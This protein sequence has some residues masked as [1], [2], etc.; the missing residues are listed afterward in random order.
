MPHLKTIKFHASN[1]V[2]TEALSVKIN[3]S[4]AG[5]FYCYLP[6]YLLPAVRD[7]FNIS[8]YIE[9]PEKIKVTET[10]LKELEF[11]IQRSLNIY[12]KPEILKYPVIL[13]N[14]ESHTSFAEDKDGNIFP[15]AGFNGASWKDDRDRYGNHHASNP[16]HGGYSLIIGAQAKM[17]IIH[18]YGT[19]EKIKY[20]PYYNGG[21]H[22]GNK[23]PAELLNSWCSYSLGDNPKEMAYTDDAALFFY[24]LMMGMAKLSKIIQDK[25]FNQIDLLTMIKDKSILML[26]IK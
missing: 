25:T 22:L 21:H 11:N 19:I 7:S 20:K 6:G 2:E 24:D 4:A 9:N 15:N 1:E 10:T 17:K 23:N 13:Y 18:K 26:P 14:I 5:D 12:T 16:S 8:S 3:I